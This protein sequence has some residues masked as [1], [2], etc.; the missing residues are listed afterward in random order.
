MNASEWAA[1]VSATASVMAVLAAIAAGVIAYRLW[2][3]D[4]QRED[5]LERGEQRS[6]AA[7]VAA[8]IRRDDKEHNQAWDPEAESY[9]LTPHIEPVLLLLNTSSVPIYDV[10]ARFVLDG[11]A[12]GEMRWELL[13]PNVHPTALAI[14]GEHIDTWE[15]TTP[16][17]PHQNVATKL[18]VELYFRDAENRHW[19]RR[20]D[21]SLEQ[22]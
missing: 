16:W 1:W 14:T 7:L 18:L 10:I 2:E 21:G 6:Q 22:L 4:E 19:V 11:E 12:V 9:H 5:R 13:Q 15:P 8:W 17:W 20:T 3:N